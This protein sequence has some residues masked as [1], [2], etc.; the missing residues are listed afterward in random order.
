MIGAVFKNLGG[1]ALEDARLLSDAWKKTLLS[2]KGT[3]GPSPEGDA[4]TY[5][6][7]LADHSRILDVKNGVLII[8]TDHPGWTQLLQ[9]H[10]AY[11][12]TGLQRL[13]PA[14]GIRAL[15]FRLAS[16]AP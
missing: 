14:E 16:R 13:V 6:Q 15:A 7:R 4:D 1:N 12:I 11:I 8:E 5:G 9:I 3:G 10:R 2:L